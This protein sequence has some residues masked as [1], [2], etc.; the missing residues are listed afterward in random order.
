[1]ALLVALLVPPFSRSAVP[2]AS[3]AGVA[4]AGLLDAAAFFLLARTLQTRPERFEARWLAALLCKFAALGSACGVAA[5]AAPAAAT[6]FMHAVAIAFAVHVVHS[7]WTL[8]PLF[9]ARPS[10]E[11]SR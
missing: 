9:V 6:A 8:G 2:A 1:M 11:G 4:F 10:R 7:A 5:L 3:A